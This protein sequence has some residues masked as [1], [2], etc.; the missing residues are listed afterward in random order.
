MNG[1]FVYFTSTEAGG[2]YATLIDGRIYALDAQTGQQKWLF[3]IDA[4][5]SSPAIANQ[6][7]YVGD[8]EGHL[9][10]VRLRD[11]KRKVETES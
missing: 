7:L 5:L 1:N 3:K 8:S 11:R 6:T 10:G 4:S 9:H 2:A